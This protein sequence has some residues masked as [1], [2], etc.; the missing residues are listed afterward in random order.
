MPAEVA[1]VGSGPNGLAAAVTMARAGLSV[2]VFERN[3][4]VG[5]GAST[6]EITLP[7]FRHDLASAVHPMALAS[8]FFQQFELSRRIRLL[9]PEVSFAHPLPDGRVGVGHRDLQSAADAMGADGPAYERLMR[10]LVDR[11]GQLTTLTSGALLQR[12]VH[13]TAAAF[14]GA[15]TLEQGCAVWRSRFS[16]EVA[17]A[18]LTGCA[19]HTIGRHP[20]LTTAAA[21]LLLTA[22]AHAAGWPVPEG[23]S[24]AISD[25][26][27]TDLGTYGGAIHTGIGITSAAQLKTYRTVLFDVSTKALAALGGDRF[28]TRYQCALRQLHHGNGVCKVDYALDGP[29][30][31]TS[32]ALR[33]TPTIHLGGTR[34]QIAASECAV[35]RGKLSDQPY[36]LVVQPGVVDTTRAP[37]G[38]ATLWAYTHVPFGSPLDRSE[39][40]TAMIER[41]APGF[42]DLILAQTSTTAS[43][44]ATVSDNFAGGDFAVGAV[45]L[46]Q[47]LRRP[48]LSPTPWRTP[49]DGWY[50]ASSAASPGP[51][52]HGLAGWHAA[53]TA[54]RDQYQLP[55]PDLG[56][57]PAPA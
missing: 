38:K 15:R 22:H 56:L 33:N 18:M 27:A 13:P 45:T 14:F 16:D 40:M 5:G 9:V 54:L 47:L 51:S 31:W 4:W 3:D 43:D 6:R 53:S 48:V 42:R 34:D 23:G 35:A 12:P 50:L 8:P 29:V 11:I 26:L 39:A 41:L 55:P 32:A 36:V 28:S 17:P 2:D 30:P 20:S 44:F 10:P 49:V 21:G 52:V 1:V 7:G 24:Q 25:A 46:R 19:A 37:A 57:E